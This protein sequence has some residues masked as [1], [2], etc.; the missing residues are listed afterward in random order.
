MHHLSFFK[1]LVAVATMSIAACTTSDVRFASTPDEPSARIAS[2]YASL[3][4]VKVT[5][6]VYAATEEIFVENEDGA[7]SALGPLWADDPARAMTLQLARDLA[8]ITGARVAPEPW[9]FRDIADARVDVRVEEMLAMAAGTYRISGQFFIAPDTAG[10]DRSGLFSVSVPLPAE[11]TP[12]QIAAARGTATS[13][14]AEE[15]VRRGLR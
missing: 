11:A 5:L 4:V 15:I 6:P 7:I 8:A 3:E 1:V 2:R 9:P 12:S 14:L 10:P 13:S